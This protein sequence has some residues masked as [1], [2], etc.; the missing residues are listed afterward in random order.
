LRINLT[1][2]VYVVFDAGIGYVQCMPETAPPAMFCE[3]QSKESWP[4]LA[5][6]LT[7]ERVARL[8]RVGYQDPG[9]T[10]NYWKTYPL[11]KFADAAI[12]NELLTILYDVYVYTGAAKLKVKTEQID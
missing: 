4:A 8:H 2:R 5:A 10:P 1:R 12:A 3:A 7:P 9:R 6:I 11:D